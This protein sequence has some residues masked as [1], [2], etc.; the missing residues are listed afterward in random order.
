MRTTAEAELPPLKC[1]LVDVRQLVGVG[2]GWLS[3]V[4]FGV[5]RIDRFGLWWCCGGGVA[6]CLEVGG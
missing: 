1:C 4:L 3:V 6:L 5:G 2:S